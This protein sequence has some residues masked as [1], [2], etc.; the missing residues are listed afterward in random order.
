MPWPTLLL[1]ASR[2]SLFVLLAVPADGEERCRLGPSGP[3]DR[4]Y[5]TA[6]RPAP[7][8]A[9]TRDLVVRSLPREGTVNATGPAQQAKLKAIEEVLRVHQRD[10]IYEVRVIDVPQAWTGLHGGSVLLI[11]LP[12]LTQVTAEELQALVAHEIGHEYLF[13]DYQ[14]A[15]ADAD[16]PRLRRLET[17]S[18]AIA[19]LTLLELGIPVARLT[20]ALEKVH[21]YNRTRLGIAANER[22]YPGMQDR[23]RQIAAYARAGGATSSSASRRPRAD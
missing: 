19:A 9:A 15:H 6:C 22:S 5:L 7:V 10:G 12:A 8:S 20:S 2:V 1:T 3:G 17:V 11:S 16:H 23:R 21:L 14:L 13:A 4:D 18:D